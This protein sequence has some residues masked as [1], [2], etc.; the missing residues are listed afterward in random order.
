VHGTATTAD[1]LQ[2]CYRERGRTRRERLHRARAVRGAASKL[3]VRVGRVWPAGNVWRA[4]PREP[5]GSALGPNN[6]SA[7]DKPLSGKGK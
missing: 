4:R 2:W 7:V 1:I 6:S 3:A 5:V